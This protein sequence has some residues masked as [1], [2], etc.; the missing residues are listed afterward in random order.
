MTPVPLTGIVGGIAPGGDAF[1]VQ[2]PWG[3]SGVQGQECG[4][5]RGLVWGCGT[6][7]GV[8]GLVWVL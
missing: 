6:S 5:A 7:V 8:V 2:P 4:S 3:G 1:W